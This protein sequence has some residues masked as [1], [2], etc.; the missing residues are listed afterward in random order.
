M[1]KDTSI[2]NLKVLFQKYF[3]LHGRYPTQEEMSAGLGIS[4]RTLQRIYGGLSKVREL[5]NLP[6][7]DYT[8]GEERSKK[9]LRS[10][11]IS[12]IE[13]NKIYKKLLPI[14]REYYIHQQAPYG[15]NGRMRSDFKI[16]HSQGSFYVDIFFADNLRNMTGCINAKLRKFNPNFVWGK[17]ILINTNKSLDNDL[18]PLIS[19]RKIPLPENVT[20]MTESEFFDYCNTL[21]PV[22]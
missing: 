18:A 5:C 10:F 1:K 16:F 13:Q 22:V 12:F 6:I 9:A 20:V 21:T 4:G 19:R 3:E 14:F 2:E 17:V 7:L 11:D 15:D 8:R